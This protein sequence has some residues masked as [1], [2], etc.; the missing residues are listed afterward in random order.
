[1]GGNSQLPSWIRRNGNSL[2]STWPAFHRE[3]TVL[4]SSIDGHSCARRNGR[5]SFDSVPNWAIYRRMGI[6]S[7]S[8]TVTVWLGSF[9]FHRSKWICHMPKPASG[10]RAHN[11]DNVAQVR[12]LWS[13]N[14]MIHVASITSFSS[15]AHID[16][17]LGILLPRAAASCLVTCCINLPKPWRTERVRLFAAI[18]IGASHE[19]S[20]HGGTGLPV[21]WAIE[22]GH[23]RTRKRPCQKLS[24]HPNA[25]CSLKRSASG[26][27]A[28]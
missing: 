25:S 27:E 28:C 11:T 1:M 9:T 12:S 4:Q 13:Y 15:F 24:H 8:L 22:R 2:H 18:R 14:G 26:R 7:E 3:L 5:F 6:R 17:V 10:E 16:C 20:D 23:F 21:C 19:N